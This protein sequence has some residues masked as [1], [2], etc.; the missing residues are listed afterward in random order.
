MLSAW[1]VGQTLVVEGDETDIAQ[2]NMLI[3]VTHA[4]DRYLAS[5]EKSSDKPLRKK[6]HLVLLWCARQCS[7]LQ[8]RQLS[9]IVLYSTC[10]TSS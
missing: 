6:K 10:R 2:E 3:L 1:D 7:Q 4:V 5:F 8:S 9:R